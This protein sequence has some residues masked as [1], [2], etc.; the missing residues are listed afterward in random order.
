VPRPLHV[1]FESVASPFA[2]HVLVGPLTVLW[3]ASSIVMNLGLAVAV[4]LA[5]QAV[6]N[7]AVVTWAAGGLMAILPLAIG[8]A[9]LRYRLYDLNR[10]VSRTLTYGLLTVL[11]G[12][13]YTLVVLG[14]GQLLGH[15]FS[16]AVAGATLAVA[17][18]FQPA[19]RRV[20]ALVD[21]RFNRRRYDAAQTIAAFSARLRD[22]IDLTTLT[23]ELL[24]VVETTIQPTQASL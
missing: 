5:G 6:G 23:G 21:R 16:L 11:L 14:L 12:G 13:G 1:P 19:R 24:A 3:A 2:V 7:D 10:I 22:Q 17:A 9:F 4:A 18:L 8:A 15:R 20:Q